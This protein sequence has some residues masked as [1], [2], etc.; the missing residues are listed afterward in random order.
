[1]YHSPSSYVLQVSMEHAVV[2]RE[3][4]VIIPT[5]RCVVP[6]Y[7]EENVWGQTV[8]ITTSHEKTDTP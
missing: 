3:H 7:L 8:T 2:Q 6:P 4:I 1:M 5:Q